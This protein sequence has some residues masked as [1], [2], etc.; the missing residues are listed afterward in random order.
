[1][2]ILFLSDFY[3]PHIK[4]GAEVST[5]LFCEWLAKNQ[6]VSVLCSRIATNSWVK[7]NVSIH[8]VLYK[9]IPVSRHIIP[10]VKYGVSIVLFPLIN[11]INTLIF[12]IKLN[13][14]I[15][16]V[17]P[18]SYQFMPVIIAM[19]FLTNKQ[20]V[21]DCRDY[22]LICPTNLSSE[23]FDDTKQKKHG[24][25]CLINYN[26]DNKFLDIFKHPFA[27]YE[28]TIFN[29]YKSFLIFVAN[30]N[31]KLH[32]VANSNYVKSQLVMNGFRPEIIS[33]I[34]NMC[35][36]SNYKVSKN[37]KINIPIFVYA[38]RVERSKGVFEIIYATE[39][40]YKL[41]YKFKVQIVGTGKIL[42][43]LKTYVKLRHINNVEFIGQIT[44]QQV[45]ELYRKS[46]AIMGP[47]K[48][49]EPF[50]RFILEA[51]VAGVPV[52]ATRTGGTPEG[53]I[54]G[55]TGFMYDSGNIE[56][57]I[58]IMKKIIES[59]NISSQMRKN[60]SKNMEDYLPEI[61][62]NKR[63]QLYTYLLAGKNV[64]V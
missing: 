28:S 20:I 35:D 25:D 18:S 58:V 63:I 45:L 53:V 24:Y 16:Q 32:L 50:G 54:D 8:P 44:P 64:N 62:G 12:S 17:V 36:I 27:I 5:S 9:A 7:D 30:R 61:V 39:V 38:G 34:R 23:M 40:L 51:L 55:K 1:M 2:K 19:R 33:V 21:V 6:S 57:L 42:N 29:A 47:S 59:P 3:P 26:T 48:W 37:S 22:S 15:I 10:A 60:I 52:I 46:V 14:D 31:N 49:P 4:G 41:G 13:P 11:I 43:D 56:Q